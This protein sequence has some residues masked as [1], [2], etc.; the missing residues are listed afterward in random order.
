MAG[1]L[2]SVIRHRCGRALAEHA[3]ERP[4]FSLLVDGDYEERS[5][6]RSI[7]YDA[8]SIETYR[9]FRGRSVGEDVQFHRIQRACRLLV[10]G[11]PIG[12]VAFDC[13][14]TDQSYFTRVFRRLTGSMPAAFRRRMPR[15][16]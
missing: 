15:A 16:R 9:A 5:G 3:H 14:F 10:A 12:K 13:G 2:L 11:A 6:G 1:A 8:F 7:V 4:Y